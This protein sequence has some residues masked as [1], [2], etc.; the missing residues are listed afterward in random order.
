M[1]KIK[2]TIE[3]KKK[4]I[5][6]LSKKLEKDFGEGILIGANDKPK[7]HDYIPTGSIGL[8]KALGIGGLPKGRIVE[9]YGPESSGK[10]TLA[11]HVMAEAHKQDP[12]AMCAFVDAE[13]AFDVS[14][15]EKVGVDLSR[16]KITQPSYGEQ[17]LEVAER[18]CE[19]GDFAVVVVDSV[20]ALVPK[21]EVD[22]DMGESSM[23]KH[24]LLMSQA[25]RKLTPVVSESNTL[26]IFINQL[27]EK[28]VMMGNPEVTTGG[29][30]L[31]FYA[32]VRLDIRKYISKE[33]LVMEDGVK[34]GNLVK[35]KVVKN[36]VSPPFRECEFN[37]LWGEGIDKFSELIDVAVQAG[38]IAKSGGWY[39]VKD[40]RL[41][42]LASVKQYLSE[43][44]EI[45]DEIKKQVYEDYVPV[46]FEPE[47]V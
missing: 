33:Q 22:R 11:I 28:M 2:E 31:K 17:A 47:E 30:A 39:T 20:A 46:E 9:I 23:G 44:S 42:G 26:L 6:E 38:I 21:A 36:K 32:S 41:Q 40:K 7:T 10:T 35:V 25:M 12:N 34:K 24:A 43:N 45:F 29:N 37:I 19:S 27:R 16:L 3:E 14:Y 15:A 8:D 5:S 18:L 13:H 1:E 4:R